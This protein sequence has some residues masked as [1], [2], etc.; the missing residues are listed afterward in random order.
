MDD[1]SLNKESSKR[2]KYDEGLGEHHDRFLIREGVEER[3]LSA[4]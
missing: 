4:L 2:E 1:A 3:N